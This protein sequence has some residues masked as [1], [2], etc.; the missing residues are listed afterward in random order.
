MARREVSE[1]QERQ[2]ELEREN[3]IMKAKLSNA[4]GNAGTSTPSTIVPNSRIPSVISSPRNESHASPS[5]SPTFPD[6][7]SPETPRS[8][9]LFRSHRNNR[10]ST[11]SSVPGFEA[12]EFGSPLMSQTIQFVSKSSNGSYDSPVK[13]TQPTS[14]IPFPTSTTSFALRRG[15]KMSTESSTTFASHDEF[16]RSF[17]SA[18]SAPPLAEDL[19]GLKER[20]A[21]FLEDL[22]NEVPKETLEEQSI[23][24]SHLLS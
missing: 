6:K 4:G 18:S 8:T 1:G 22:T 11:T 3:M 9:A 24:L 23:N 15:S 5:T 19:R 17:D 10:I 13:P 2:E 16:D 20:D 14:R 21:A 7:H 12:L